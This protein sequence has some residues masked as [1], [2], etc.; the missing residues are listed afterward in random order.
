MAY[1]AMVYG[2]GRRSP[3]PVAAVAQSYANDVTDEFM[4]PV[5]VR[6]RRHHLRQ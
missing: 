3:D 4:E 5:V 6:R 2:E 1:D